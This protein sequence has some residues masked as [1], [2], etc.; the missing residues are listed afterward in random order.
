MPAS[1]CSAQKRAAISPGRLNVGILLHRS[2]VLFF[3][4]DHACL[5]V[6]GA[7]ARR[8]LARSIERRA[9]AAP[10]AGL[11]HH[12]DHACLLV[13]G[14]KARLRLARSIE[15][16]AL[17]APFAGLAYHV[18]H[19]CLLVLGAEARLRLARS[20]ERRALAAPF[21]GLAHHVDHACLLVLGAKARLR[22]ARS[23]ERRALAAPFAGL[24]YHV[25]HACLLVL[26]AKARLR[27]TRLIE[28]RALSAPFAGLAYHV[29][30][31]CLL[32]LGAKARL[33]L[34]RLIERG[35]LA[36]PFAGPVPLPAQ[37]LSHDA[38]L[39]SLVWAIANV[40]GSEKKTPAF[41][42]RCG[43]PRTTCFPPCLPPS[44][45][46]SRGFAEP[47]G[48]SRAR[49]WTPATRRRWCAWCAASIGGTG[50]TPSRTGSRGCTP[51]SRPTR[52]CL[53]ASPSCSRAH[54][55]EGSV[56]DFCASTAYALAMDAVSRGHVRY[57]NFYSV[58]AAQP[59]TQPC[60]PNPSTETWHRL[61]PTRSH[62]TLGNGGS[63]A[64][65]G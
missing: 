32:V 45:A 26:G 37:H 48:R 2:Q 15:R 22:L 7:K 23:I 21:A 17:A 30:H 42:V 25:D 19:A 62:P 50:R 1:L 16:R 60:R 58:A 53:P 31:A 36:A 47:R 11:A 54:A 24:A 61:R 27:L 56:E 34:A 43:P 3:H 35:D 41:R 59:A 12:V 18:D 38:T 28:R 6:L 52:L 29:D 14:A 65:A 51:P 5:L 10:F 13:L 9:L 57:S 63:G 20:I 40:C 46:G 8:R 44:P 4:V 39:V 49:C 64:P 55:G 33:R